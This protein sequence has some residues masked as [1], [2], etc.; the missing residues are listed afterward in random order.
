MQVLEGTFSRLCREKRTVAQRNQTL[1]KLCFL[2]LCFGENSINPF[3]KDSLLDMILLGPFGLA[4]KD[5]F[6]DYIIFKGQSIFWGKRYFGPLRNMSRSFG[7]DI[8]FMS[9]VKNDPVGS[10]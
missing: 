5:T 1:G 3:I 8:M 2:A 6:A 9:P 10:N 4:V 7:F